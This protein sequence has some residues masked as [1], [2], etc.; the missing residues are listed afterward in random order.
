MPKKPDSTNPKARYQFAAS[1][2]D[3]KKADRLNKIAA[4][5]NMSRSRMCTDLLSRVA[6]IEPDQYLDL[7]KLIDG[8]KHK[9]ISITFHTKE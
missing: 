4:E 2:S 7:L 1:L 3:K 8:L 5:N 6:E 9:N